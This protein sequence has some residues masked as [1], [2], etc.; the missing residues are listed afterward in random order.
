MVD[1][2][3]G[4]PAFVRSPSLNVTNVSQHGQVRSHTRD[5]NCLSCHQEKG[6]G[7]GVFTLAGSLADEKGRPVPNA[8]LRLFA[9]AQAPGGG[10]VQFGGPI[11]LANEVFSAE[12]DGNGNFFTTET[13]PDTFPDLPL[14]PQFFAE[15]GSV[16][17]KADG[18]APAIMGSGVQVGGCNFCHGSSFRIVGRSDAAAE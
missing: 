14:Y 12:V 8:T 5:K 15:D 9:A 1:F 10:P 16:L 7:R 4:D 3:P 11:E 18:K 17:F 6:P 13:L 2:V